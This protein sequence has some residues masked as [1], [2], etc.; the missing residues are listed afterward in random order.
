MVA[1]VLLSVFSILVL[2]IVIVIMI[3]MMVVVM[4]VLVLVIAPVVLLQVVVLVVLL[5]VVDS[6]LHF[7]AVLRIHGLLDNVL[8]VE[9]LCVDLEV[10]VFSLFQKRLGRVRIEIRA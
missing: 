5:C 8:G 7:E 6:E 3:V 1:A 9:L 2:F 4:L 10:S